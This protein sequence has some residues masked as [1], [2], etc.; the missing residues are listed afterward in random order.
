MNYKSRYNKC[1]KFISI[2]K[3]QRNYHGLPYILYFA[4]I[5]DKEMQVPVTVDP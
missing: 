3:I 5:K 4:P 2:Q 1:E